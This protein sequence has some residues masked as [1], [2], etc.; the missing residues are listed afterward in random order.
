MK[1]VLL[2]EI[3]IIATALILGYNMIISVL[4]LLSTLAIMLETDIAQSLG[5][6][7]LPAIVIFVFYAISFF[8]L[9]RYRRSLSR[10]ISG[11]GDESIGIRLNKASIL[12]VVIVAVCFLTLL[13]SVPNVIEY[14]VNKATR[15]NEEL[16]DNTR[17]YRSNASFVNSLISLVVSTIILITSKNIAGFFGKEEQSFEIAGEKIENQ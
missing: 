11:Q 4:T 5:I 12:Q 6:A 7:L 15:G 10:F 13:R 3:G 9:V 2:V 14:L 16:L 1:K 17:V 8:L